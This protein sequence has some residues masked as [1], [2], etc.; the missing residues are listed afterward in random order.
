MLDLRGYI[1][2]PSYHLDDQDRMIV[3]REEI[4]A[5]IG[6]I[7][8]LASRRIAVCSNHWHNG[9]NITFL[10]GFSNHGGH[11]LDAVEEIANLLRPFESRLRGSL[12]VH[13]FAHD[14]EQE[15]TV[16]VG[17]GKPFTHLD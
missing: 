9:E 4:D 14:D 7:E 1:L 13:I 15:R 10:A 16:V 11:A 8:R 17:L 5:L 12:K 6:G 2:L 3:T